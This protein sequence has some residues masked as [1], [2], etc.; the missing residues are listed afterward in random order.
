MHHLPKVDGVTPNSPTS[1]RAVFSF[2]QYKFKRLLSSIFASCF[3]KVSDLF[4]ISLRQRKNMD[5]FLTLP[6]FNADGIGA[7]VDNADDA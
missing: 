2:K 3:C 1:Q 7:Y 6:K 5:L 4:S